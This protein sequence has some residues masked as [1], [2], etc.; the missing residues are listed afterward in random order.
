M[1]RNV[2]DSSKLPETQE[3]T[4]ASLAGIALP[5]DDALGGITHINQFEDSSWIAEKNSDSVPLPR[6]LQQSWIG[7]D[8][9]LL[10]DASSASV[11]CKYD[12]GSSSYQPLI[13]RG[14]RLAKR[15]SKELCPSE[16]KVP[17]TS[18]QQQEDEDNESPPN[19]PNYPKIPD[20]I[21]PGRVDPRRT[22]TTRKSNSLN[23][24]NALMLLYMN[25]G[26]DGNSN[27]AVC[28]RDRDHEV[29]ICAPFLAARLSPADIVKPCRF[30]EFYLSLLP[31][32]WAHLGDRQ[33]IPFRAATL[34]ESGKNKAC[35]TRLE[36]CAEKENITEFIL[37]FSGAGQT[38]YFCEFMLED[39]WC[40]KYAR[41]PDFRA[42]NS[43]NPGNFRVSKKKS[44]QPYANYNWA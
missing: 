19:L 9:E 22:R 15:Q 39:L 27:T 16:P 30:C 38:N 33:T 31:F 4:I 10:P 7:G 20:I 35:T 44:T 37:I 17:T 14:Q 3:D 6:L 21:I 5:D 24:Q 34:E 12:T 1:H 41:Q 23:D 43:I 13:P 25:P 28:N 18:K 29:P 40:C 36:K 26:F 32:F 11:N 42:L 8:S 2:A